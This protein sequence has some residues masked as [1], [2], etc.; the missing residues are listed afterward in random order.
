VFLVVIGKDWLPSSTW[1]PSRL[2]SSED[3]VRLEI[4]AALK[5]RKIHIIPV[6]VHGAA[7]PPRTRLPAD[8]APLLDWNAVHLRENTWDENVAGLFR[9]IDKLVPAA[10][11]A[12]KSAAKGRASAK[13]AAATQPELATGS[14][15]RR[16]AGEQSRGS[17]PRAKK[18]PDG[19]VPQPAK[20]SR[21][22]AAAPQK[23][24]SKQPRRG[25]DTTKP[26]EKVP[27]RKPR[28][29]PAP[30]RKPTASKTPPKKKPLSDGP[31][32]RSRRADG[33]K[34]KDRA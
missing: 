26:G 1:H 31:R 15:K 22:S 12:A 14:S 30:E 27:A 6:L 10:K 17:S 13:T 28:A 33:G 29:K 34:T 8:L 21:G 18:K 20:S 11:P 16:A 25:A 3:W 2:E 24:S 7:M 19:T 32:R 9:M 5:R 23:S 4:T